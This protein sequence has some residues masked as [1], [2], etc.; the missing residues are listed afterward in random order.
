MMFWIPILKVLITI[1]IIG[2]ISCFV[3]KEVFKKEGN[4]F[5]DID[6]SPYRYY[7]KN[8][9]AAYKKEYKIKSK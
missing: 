9:K 7:L 1:G 6:F 5:I 4:I 8:L 3:Y 2:V